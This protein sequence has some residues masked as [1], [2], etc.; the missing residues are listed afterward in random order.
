M[1][2][3][4]ITPYFKESEAVLRRGMDSVQRQTYRNFVHYMVADG[5]PRPEVMEGYERVVAVN[6]PSAHADYGCTPRSVGALLALNEGA[7]VA[8][9]LDADNLFEP[10]HLES[11]VSAYQRAIDD[12]A[13]LDAVFGSRYIFLPGHEHLR[14]VSQEDVSRQHVDTSCMSFHRSAAFVWT[15]WGMIPRAATPKCDRLMFDLVRAHRL[16]MEWTDRWT[17]LYESN[18]SYDY[19]QAGI[20]IPDHGLHDAT[21]TD[22]QLPS[23]EMLARLRIRLQVAGAA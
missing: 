21:L 17:V 19:Q 13:P 14:L 8:C 4:V 23:D 15:L 22:V 5:H 16:R 2:V 9:F 1:K 12:G 20:P 10:E 6:L 18:W 11:L 3:A 7:D